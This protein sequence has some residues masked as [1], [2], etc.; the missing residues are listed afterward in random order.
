MG[1]L[2][3]ALSHV[4]TIDPSLMFLMFLPALIFE[5]AFTISPHIIKREM[6]QALLLAVPGLVIAAFLTAWACQLIFV[7]YNWS[8]EVALLFGALISATDPVAVV[9][10]LRELGSSKR[11]ATLIEA[12]S[13]LNDASSVVLFLIVQERVQGLFRPIGETFFVL[14]RLTLGGF[15]LGT[16]A[17]ALCVLW[18]RLMFRDHLTETSATMCI[19]YLSFWVAESLNLQ[20]SGVLTSVFLG[21]YLANHRTDM[22]VHD[23]ASLDHVWHMISFVAN[24]IL[25]TLS[26]AIVARNLFSSIYSW[27][28]FGYLIG[29]YVALHII[30]FAA[31]LAMAPFI[32]KL[33]YGLSWTDSLIV[34]HGGLRGAIALALALKVN[35]D[36]NIDKDTRD[37]FLFHSCGI[38]LLTLV[39][40]GSTMRYIVERIDR[41]KAATT[42]KP[43]VLGRATAFI[44]EETATLLASLAHDEYFRG[45]DIER[46]RSHLPALGPSEP[47]CPNNEATRSSGDEVLTAAS[48]APHPM[49]FVTSP[50]GT[51]ELPTLARVATATSGLA[52]EPVAALLKDGRQ[53]RLCEYRQIQCLT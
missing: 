1:H 37:R 47:P 50:M 44:E 10:L 32:R 48:V 30:R 2:G 3:G 43:T 28:D 6:G 9:A 19:A 14:F 40:N 45:A 38:V 12:E 35:L 18:I 17:G 39:I 24:T 51:V 20:V 34:V 33:G 13:L 5:S 25:F 23:E 22:S 15:M 21:L 7:S 26:G 53:V 4:I 46:I 16:L 8:F 49:Q 36:E 27:T 31:V 42:D 52:G 29:M 41:R 11:L